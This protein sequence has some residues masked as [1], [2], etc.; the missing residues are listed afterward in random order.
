MECTDIVEIGPQDS[1]KPK[2]EPRGQRPTV[3]AKK[4]PKREMKSPPRTKRQFAESLKKRNAARSSQDP[5]DHLYN[6]SNID[7]KRKF[8]TENKNIKKDK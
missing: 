3:T 2:R 8:K 6:E 1:P 4:E 7:R 5:S